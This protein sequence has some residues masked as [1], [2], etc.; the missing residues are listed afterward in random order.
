MSLLRTKPVL[1]DAADR[2]LKRVLGAWDLTLLGV[3]AVIGAGIFVLTGITAATQAGPAVVISFLIAGFAC[4]C[5]A[6]SY[7]ELASSVG[8][9]GSAYGYGYASLGELPAWVIGW[10][11]L[12]EYMVA[13]PAVA[14]GWS[15][16][17][18]NFLQSL[19]SGLPDFLTHGPIDKL[20]PGLINLPAFLIVLAIGLLLASGAKMSALFNAIMVAV[21]VAAILLFIGVAAFHI[22][23]QNWTPFIPPLEITAGSAAGFSWE[24]RLLD[25][26]ELGL[27]FGGGGETHFGV[28][29]IMT[30]AA[31][32][33]FAYLGFDAVS[34]AAEETRNPQRDLPIGILGSLA[35]CT[36]LYIVV[37]LLLTGMVSY[38]DLNVPSPVA[39]ALLQVGQTTAAGIISIGAIAGLTTVILVMYFGLTRVLFAIAHDGLLPKLFAYV[40]PKSGTPIGSIAAAGVI[41]LA[42]SGFVPLG[43]L[44]E[45]AN[46]GTL[47]AFVVVCA[48]VIVMR[49]THPDLPRPFRTPASPLIPLLG[50]VSC[51]YLMLNLAAFTWTAFGAWMLIG[52]V[53]YF[54]YS[55]SHSALANAHN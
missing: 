2:G 9:A 36:V 5:A 19:G 34:T 7:A 43:R 39:S 22:D 30:G 40:N 3:G 25:A 55:R 47:G 21:K 4:A 46:I 52:L 33:F 27:G 51:G 28:V 6:L 12:C 13:I 41:M 48:G 50:M 24:M 15:G 31:T 42:F 1:P 29:G 20:T 8:G 44:A 18:V 45:L 11:L 54:A 35:I 53:V 17:V 23:A 10:M 32:I 26:I 38:R 14:T 16:Y 49:R 37:S